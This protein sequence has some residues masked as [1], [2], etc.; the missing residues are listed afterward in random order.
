LTGKRRVG[1]V[2]FILDSA[3]TSALLAAEPVQGLETNVPEGVKQ[4]IGKAGLSCD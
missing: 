3:E 4:L 2:G 1:T